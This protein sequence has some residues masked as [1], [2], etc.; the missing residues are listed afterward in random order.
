MKGSAIAEIFN[1]HTVSFFVAL[2]CVSSAI[3][4]IFNL[5]TVFLAYI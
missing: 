3:A 2:V 4:E 1:L 5:H